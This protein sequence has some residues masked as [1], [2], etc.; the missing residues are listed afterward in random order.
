MERPLTR[1]TGPEDHTALLNNLP[2]AEKRR[3][4]PS[5]VRSLESP[6]NWGL[7]NNAALAL[8]YYE[9]DGRAAVPALV[10]ALKDASPNVQI[11][12]AQ[13]LNRISPIDARKAR[14]VSVVTKVLA[15]PDDQVA[16]KA[17]DVLRDFSD[18][19]EALSGLV[20]AL[21]STNTLVACSAVWALERRF[22]K[23][24]PAVLPALQEAAQ[25]KDN[26]AGYARSALKH[27]DSNANL[28]TGRKRE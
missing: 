28:N 25:R 22:Q 19:P 1:F 24:A 18:E 6:S 15:H 11:Y 2:S 9:N 27:L 17:A 5:F 3:L 16:S 7:R 26:V 10:T 23:H 20:N 13:A 12:A 21:R 14:A 8:R 4:L